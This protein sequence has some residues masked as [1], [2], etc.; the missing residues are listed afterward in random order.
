MFDPVLPHNLEAY[1]RVKQKQKK[2]IIAAV[3]TGPLVVVLPASVI[4]YVAGFLFFG[5]MSVY[6][7]FELHKARIFR[8]DLKERQLGDQP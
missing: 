7:L 8:R 6:A 2:T 5:F 4:P 1:D 3:V